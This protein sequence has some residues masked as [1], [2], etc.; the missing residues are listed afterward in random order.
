M[1][2]AHDEDYGFPSIAL[3]FSSKKIDK[4]FGVWSTVDETS[5]LTIPEFPRFNAIR[6]TQDEAERCRAQGGV[7]SI[8]IH[9][10]E[11]RSPIRP[12]VIGATG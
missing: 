2:R 4:E 11:R 8:S 1:P 5:P 12:L 3:G 10:K 9:D 7:V 6:R